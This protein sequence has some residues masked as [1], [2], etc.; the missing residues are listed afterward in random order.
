MG[1]LSLAAP[2]TAN[3]AEPLVLQPSSAWNIDYSPESCKLG[4]KFGEGDNAVTI[5]LTKS[6]P[7]PKMQMLAIGKPLKIKWLGDLRYGWWP[8]LDS[9]PLESGALFG[10]SDGITSM[11]LMTSLVPFPPNPDEPYLYTIGDLERQEKARAAEITEFRF[12]KGVKRPVT[13]KLG[14][15]SAPMAALDTCLDALVEHWGL[16]PA[17]QRRLRRPVTPANEPHK[18]VTDSDYPVSA[19]KHGRAAI[20]DFR[21]LVD[22]EGEI[23]R[24]DPI[25][26]FVESDF[27]YGLCKLIKARA[28]MTPALG[29]DG[30]PV[31]SYFVGTIRY[32]I[33]S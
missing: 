19:A 28:Q 32:Q 17:I 2:A 11:L 12:V 5:V 8:E 23:T 30:E 22:E 31:A 20:I 25:G 26:T 7:G 29:P 6:A 33:S 1:A 3:A 18:W 9:E 15:M 10:E 13:L 21:V 16:D 4:R 24:C 14:G 27:S